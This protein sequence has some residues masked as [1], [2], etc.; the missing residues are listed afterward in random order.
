MRWLKRAYDSAGLTQY[1]TGSHL[2][3]VQALFGCNVILC[4]DVSG[5]MSIGN[6]LSQAVKGSELFIAEAL[7]SGYS[8]GGV[9]WHHDIHA[10]TRGLSRDREEVD[11]LFASAHATGG[12]NIVPTLRLCESM[13]EG[14]TGDLVIAIFGDGDL[15]P[16]SAAVKEAHRLLEKNIRVI[17]CGLGDAS[18]AQLGAISS[19]TSTPRVAQADDIAGAI[20][21]MAAGLKR[22][23]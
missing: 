16:A 8:V 23:P 3:A 7:E 1:P 10:H 12:N 11:Q 5:S 19:E 4:L 6:R 9:L 14:K 20:A 21:G 18:A 22:R 2:A 13:L 15:G 17:T